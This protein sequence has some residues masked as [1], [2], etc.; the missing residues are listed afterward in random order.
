MHINELVLNM[1]PQRWSHNL[2]DFHHSCHKIL[3]P[4]FTGHTSLSQTIKGIT[5]SWRLK[6]RCNIQKYLKL[7]E[8]QYNVLFSSAFGVELD[9]KNERKR[10]SRNWE[11]AYL[12]IKNPKA[13]RAQVDSL[14]YL[15][16]STLLHTQLSAS[17]AALSLGKI[18]DPHLY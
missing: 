12:S 2:S 9:V 3:Q 16:H 10:V 11:N 4:H 15:C 13:S 14:L 8:V 17:E 6:S 7:I 1:I 18:L 5:F